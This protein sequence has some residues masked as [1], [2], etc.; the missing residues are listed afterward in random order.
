M[1]LQSLS[2]KQ[3]YKQTKCKLQNIPVLPKK[4]PC[5]SVE[6]PAAV[7]IWLGTQTA[8]TVVG[9]FRESGMGLE[10]RSQSVYG[11]K[12]VQVFFAMS[13]VTLATGPAGNTND[14]EYQ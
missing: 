8:C 12:S 6:K 11:L 10:K 13:T 1:P 5:V 3:A 4:L 14:S 9:L 7:G 2:I